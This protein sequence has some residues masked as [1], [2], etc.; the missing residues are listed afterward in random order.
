M[1]LFGTALGH[2]LADDLGI[3]QK[4]AWYIYTACVRPTVTTMDC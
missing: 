1:F 3:T 4:S 2:S